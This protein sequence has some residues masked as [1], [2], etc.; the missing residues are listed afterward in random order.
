MHAFT[1]FAGATMT[2]RRI[3]LALFA[4]VVAVGLIATPLTSPAHAADTDNRGLFGSQDPTG[5]GTFRQSFALLGLSATD[6]R[7]PKEAIAWLLEQQCPD[8]SFVAFRPDPAVPCPPAD[9]VNYSG[10]DTNSTAL[11]A[12]ALASHGHQKDAKRAWA[13]LRK[14]Q[15]PGG[16][17]GYVEGS[18]PDTNSTGLALAAMRVDPS[19][20][21]AVAAAVRWLNRQ[22]I[23]CSAPVGERFGMTWQ[24]GPDALANGS[25]TAQGLLGL[26]GAFPV[27]EREQRKSAPAVSCTTEARPDNPRNA[28][29]RWLSLTI[30][31]NEG[32]IPDAYSPGQADLTATALAVVGLVA[33]RTS[34]RATSVALM[35]LQE[36]AGGYVSDGTA[37]RP[38]ALGILLLAAGATGADPEDFGG[39]DLPARL[40]ATLQK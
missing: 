35:T 9:P 16:G 22:V 23:P 14:V 37:D 24:A 33:T 31:A 26:A 1:G 12:L 39:I 30:L 34:N 2:S 18:K 25:A 15:A 21:Q 3:F 40:L 27:R 32:A 8:G 7:A 28:A 17:W 5:D 11:A 19:G 6:Q 4:A 38:A 13:W 10:P 20:A 29:A 36:E